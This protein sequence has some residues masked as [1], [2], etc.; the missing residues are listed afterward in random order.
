MSM[1]V[2]LKAVWVLFDH[3]CLFFRMLSNKTSLMMDMSLEMAVFPEG[4]GAGM[5]WN[6]LEP[7]NVESLMDGLVWQSL[8]Q[9]WPLAGALPPPGPGQ[10]MEPPVEIPPLRWSRLTGEV[11]NVSHPAVWQT[12]YRVET[13]FKCYQQQQQRQRQRQE[14]MDSQQPDT[15]S[16]PGQPSQAS[17][18]S[19]WPWSHLPPE[20][21]PLIWAELDAASVWKAMCVSP[22]W[23][24]HIK[25]LAKSGKLP[26]FDASCL[27]LA[28][29]TDVIALWGRHLN[30]CI[31]RDPSCQTSWRPHPAHLFSTVEHLLLR[32]HLHC[33]DLLPTAWLRGLCLSARDRRCLEIGVPGPC[34]DP[35]DRWG[36]G[37]QVDRLSVQ[38]LCSHLDIRPEQ[39]LTGQNW[40]STSPSYRHCV[41]L[42]AAGW[43]SPRMQQQVK[44]LT[45]SLKVCPTSL[46]FNLSPETGKYNAEVCTPAVSV[47]QIHNMAKQLSGLQHFE[48]RQTGLRHYANPLFG[49]W[50]NQF[51]PLL[52]QAALSVRR[53][54]E[55]KTLTL[56]VGNHHQPSEY[57][58]LASVSCDEAEMMQQEILS[59]IFF[60]LERL[61]IE[62]DWLAAVLSGGKRLSVELVLPGPRPFTEFLLDNNVNALEAD[63]TPP[64]VPVWNPLLDVCTRWPD[65]NNEEHDHEVGGG[66]GGGDSRSQKRTWTDMVTEAVDQTKRALRRGHAAYQTFRDKPDGCWKRQM[67]AG[68]PSGLVLA[69]T[70]RQASRALTTATDKVGHV[71]LQA[72]Q[73]SSGRSDRAR[74]M[75]C[76]KV[77]QVAR[78]TQHLQET[79][80]HINLVTEEITR[81]EAEELQI[82]QS[83]VAQARQDTQEAQSQLASGRCLYDRSQWEDPTRFM[84][85][86]TCRA[87]TTRQHQINMALE[88]ALARV[89]DHTALHQEVESVRKLVQ[90]IE[91]HLQQAKAVA[92]NLNQ[93]LTGESSQPPVVSSSSRPASQQ[94]KQQQQQQHSRSSSIS[95]DDS[96]I[97]GMSVE[98][99]SM[100]HDR[101]WRELDKLLLEALQSLEAGEHFY[102]CPTFLAR[103]P[104]PSKDMGS[105]KTAVQAENYIR[106]HWL[107]CSQC[108]G[109]RKNLCC[110]PP[111]AP[112]LLSSYQQGQLDQHYARLLEEPYFALRCYESK[113]SGG[114]RD[115]AFL[116]QCCRVNQ[117]P[118]A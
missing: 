50:A 77:L 45:L 71:L 18:E 96:M 24:Y 21:W 35:M 62:H 79:Q 40:G 48:M 41:L 112:V 9:A 8:R 111:R 47:R 108:D 117:D 57:S 97:L 78:L 31:V 5:G 36:L 98:E 118:F 72:D 1:T 116:C 91:H 4:D 69:E 109:C 51:Q 19:G 28:T 44:T 59:P 75:E 92:S 15:L 12:G 66:D 6:E 73:F 87:I 90:P 30:V 115:Q 88:E 29:A 11:C 33:E 70:W 39:G 82:A 61:E 99:W 13:E 103:L 54:Y 105:L 20:I 81:R 25:W 68:E 17:E 3:I 86:A 52:V 56:W 22:T 27:T 10:V 89:P 64:P 32:C 42:H 43:I 93:A 38:C 104:Y 67:T 110:F 53:L 74:L 55:F 76:L 102:V 34:S 26:R 63:Y 107:R 2:F 85:T 80:Q 58:G 65:D 113:L 23:L 7:P 49:R 37:D 106:Q 14:Q 100:L 114:P 94:S 16:K 95:S 84:P 101:P 83:L 46:R 60:L